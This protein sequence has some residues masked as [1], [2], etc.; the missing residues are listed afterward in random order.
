MISLLN[1]NIAKLLNHQTTTQKT[2]IHM[3]NAVWATTLEI[4]T[5]ILHTLSTQV[6]IHMTRL[7]CDTYCCAFFILLFLYMNT[8]LVSTCI[9]LTM[10]PI[11]N[12]AEGHRGFSK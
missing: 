2:A 8:V 7:F 12:L 1:H 11:M 10:T 3:K 4:F 5:N 6:K 9:E